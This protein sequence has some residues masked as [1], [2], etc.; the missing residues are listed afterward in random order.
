MS[1]VD[2]AV[3]ASFPQLQ[4]REKTTGAAPYIDDFKR[5][6][7]LFGALAFSPYAHAKILGYNTEAALALPGVSAVITGEDFDYKLGGIFLK[8]EPPIAMRKVRYVGEP[9]A[10]VAA[11]DQ[12]TARRAA[13][14]GCAPRPRPR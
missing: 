3:G 11:V 5:P 12:D 9:V 14:P 7:M 2:T 10:V 1:T 4:A 6:G 8:D 13:R